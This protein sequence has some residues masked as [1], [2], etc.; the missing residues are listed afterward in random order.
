MYTVGLILLGL[1]WWW[2]MSAFTSRPPEFVPVVASY[3][4]SQFAKYL[5]GNVGQYLARHAMLRRLQLP[6]GAL[7]AAAVL[8]AASLVLAALAWALPAAGASLKSVLHISAG[9]LVLAVLVASVIAVFV[10]RML[11][12]HTRVGS[13]VSFQRPM[14]LLGVLVIHVGFFGMMVLSLVVVAAATPGVSL[15]AWLLIGVATVSWLAGFVIVGS[16]GGLGVREAVFVEL[17]RGT[18]PEPTALL[19][20]AAFRVV[21]FLG[22]LVFFV[23][24]LLA[25]ALLRR[26]SKQKMA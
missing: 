15:S 4:T 1:A 17:L 22:D 21:T 25:F 2:L 13:W 26:A 16:P 7:L 10:V 18:V 24:G 14:R 3:A 9:W 12:L 6:H 11:L 19:L 23:L 20:A 8:E 5:P